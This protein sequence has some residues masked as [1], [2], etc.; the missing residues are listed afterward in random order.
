MNAEEM[1]A[2][3]HRIRKLLEEHR[4]TSSIDGRERRLK[5]HHIDAL[6]PDIYYFVL[7]EI[8][9]AETTR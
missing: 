5:E 7:K 6:L 9:D 3:K 4:Y 1:V 8:R 2:L